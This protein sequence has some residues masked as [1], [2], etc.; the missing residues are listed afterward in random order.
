MSADIQ[1]RARELNLSIPS[2]RVK[3]QVVQ[4]TQLDPVELAAF[5]L[6]FPQIVL[7]PAKEAKQ[8]P[9]KQATAPADPEP[10]ETQEQ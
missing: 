4:L 7:D 9:K 8:K 1:K 5:K 2:I 10:N 3:G 6:Q